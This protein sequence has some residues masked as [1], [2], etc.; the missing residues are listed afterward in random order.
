MKLSDLTNKTP[1]EI[2]RMSAKQLS[3][4]VAYMARQANKRVENLKKHGYK[5]PVYDKSGAKIG[6]K[7]VNKKTSPGV[8]FNAIQN[9]NKSFGHVN[10]FT[11]I[12]TLRA[13][14][15]RVQGFLNAKSSTVAG[16]IALRKKKERALFG[17]TRGEILAKEN[18]SRKKKG[19]GP[20]TK[21]DRQTMISNMDEFMSSVYEN[22]HKWREE[23]AMEGGYTK[24]QGFTSLANIARHMLNGMPAGLA[25]YMESRRSNK[26]YETKR[27]QALAADVSEDNITAD[28]S[29]ISL[30]DDENK[31]GLF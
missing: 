29:P 18:I 7:W 27:E 22:Y 13:E 24:E 28:T 12:G 3:D 9:L 30:L 10:Q 1:D 15:I 2:N 31:D 8:D 6:T 23:Y 4:A 16:A 20:M 19:Q 5:I 14:Y 21:A 17:A 25:R 11:K 26:E